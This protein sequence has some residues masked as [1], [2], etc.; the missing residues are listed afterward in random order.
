[1][2]PSGQTIDSEDAYQAQT[3]RRGLKPALAIR[4]CIFCVRAF[5]FGASLHDH[6]QV[7]ET[8]CIFDP[9]FLA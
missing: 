3:R 1:L 4:F 2:T 9:V 5:H 8:F 6:P 7:S